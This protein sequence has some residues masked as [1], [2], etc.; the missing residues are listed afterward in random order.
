MKYLILFSVLALFCNSCN[1]GD[2]DIKNPDVRVFIEQ[3]KDCTYDEIEIAE[4]G[5]RLWTKMPDFHMK[6]VPLLISLSKDTEM[7]SP[8]GHFPVNPISSIPPYRI[9]N[10]KE[11]IMIGEFLLWC[12]EAIIAGRDFASLTPVLVN[13]NHSPEQRLTAEEILAVRKIYQDWWNKNGHMED[14]MDL[15]L[16]GTEYRWR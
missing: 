13:E 16:E 11:F 8:C 9:N 7:I 4:T 3:L 1:K 10:G 2:F 5:E 12:V 14:P 15:P 6:D